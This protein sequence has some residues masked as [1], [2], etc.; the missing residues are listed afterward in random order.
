MGEPVT[1]TAELDQ[2]DTRAFEGMLN[3][4][5][6]S[7]ATRVMPI[8]VTQRLHRLVLKIGT[9]GLRAY[10]L[11]VEAK[12]DKTGLHVHI[13]PAPFIAGLLKLL[14]SGSITHEALDDL[15]IATLSPAV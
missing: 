4:I 9:G 1:I 3:E 15:L 13:E 10:E 14:R 11:R 5:L 2:A 12:T 7:V 8:G 6:R